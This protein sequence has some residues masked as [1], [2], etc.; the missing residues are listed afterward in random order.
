[1][2]AKKLNR[3]KFILSLS[4]ACAALTFTGMRGHHN[5]PIRV[6]PIEFW[7]AGAQFHA[8]LGYSPEIGEP[9]WVRPSTHA[10]KPCFE[11]HAKKL[12]RVGYVPAKLVDE[13]PGGCD[14][15]AIVKQFEATS[16]IQYRYRIQLTHLPA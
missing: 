7:L 6:Q 15:E 12:G 8:P 1:M 14:L 11:V 3:R 2:K 13:L 5:S 10:G 9:L 4:G 16:P